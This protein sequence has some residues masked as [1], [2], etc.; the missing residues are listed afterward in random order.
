MSLKERIN[1]NSAPRAFKLFVLLLPLLGITLINKSLQ[2]DF[3]FLYPTGQ[4]IVENGFPVKD[5]LSMH[6]EMNIV[7]QQWVTDVL[8]YYIYS[9]LGRLG[10]IAFVTLCYAAFCG[11][12]YRL[13]YL[14][15]DNFFISAVCAFA[16]DMVMAQLFFSTRPQI[17][18]FNLLALELILL[19]KYVKTKSI[20]HLIPLPFVSLAIINCH[21]AMW[22][23]FF[24]LA[25]PYIAAALPLKLKSVKN[26]PCCKLLPLTVCGVIAFAFGFINPYGYNA[27]LYTVRAFENKD[28]NKYIGEMQPVDVSSS[29]G[30]LF[31][32]VFS[33]IIITA[34]FFRKKSFSL[35]FVLLFSGLSLM[36]FVN[37]KSIAL[38][39]I[40]GMASFVY[41]IKDAQVYIPVENKAENSK[42]KNAVSAILLI[43]VFLGITSYAFITQSQAQAD[44]N[45]EY[46]DLDKI[47][48]ILNNENESVILYSGFENGPYLEFRGLHPYIDCRAELFIKNVNGSYDY[49]K[50]HNDLREGSI[51]YKDFLNKY[52][53]NY[54]VI[55]RTE[56]YFDNKLS[57]D[58]DYELI[59][60]SD[61]N[62]LYKA[63]KQG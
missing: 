32:I 28:V 29:A 59:Y 45:S 53:F 41:C 55:D 27:V 50:E 43:V 2:N 49:I 52:S 13:F 24:I 56:T 63:K 58:K 5:F 26:E 46:Y 31:I 60:Q 51:Y 16:T 11:L 42:V 30:K 6:S 12:A 14:V 44:E 38:F 22:I 4:Y 39:M 33:V 7:V 20:K 9:S 10:M 17:I 61:Y 35:R 47:V 25:A 37:I 48:D 62:K 8:F 19:E 40:G 18:T 54:L 15:S 21:A 57:R 3:Y 1:I 34:V 36:A 23:M